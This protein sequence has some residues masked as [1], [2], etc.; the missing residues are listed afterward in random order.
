MSSFDKEGLYFAA[1]GGAEEVGYNMYVYAV[2]GKLIVVDCGY[3]FL[4]DDFPGMEL[5]FAS[6]EA[7]KSEIENIEGLFITHSH[8]D[9]FG[10]VA[11]IWPKLRCPIYATPFAAAHVVSR[12]KD[13]KLEKEPQI[14]IVRNGESVRL[15]NFEVR[16]A[17]LVH[18]TLENS[19]LLIRTRYGNAVHATDWRFDD[20]SCGMLPTDYEVLK[21]FAEEGVEVF[22]CDSTNLLDSEEQPTEMQIRASLMELVPTFQNKLVATCFASNVV[23]LESLI[24]AAHAAGRTPVIAGMSLNQNLNMAKEC[25]YLQNLPPYVNAKDAVDI[26]N[27]KIMYICAGSQGNYRSGL[28]RIVN[29]ENKDMILCPGDAV[30]FSSK[31]IP[32]NEKKIERMQEKLRDQGV[33]VISKEEYLVHCSGHGGKEETRRMYELLKPNV[34]I[35][36]HGERRVIREHSRFAKS[37]GIRHVVMPRNGDVLLLNGD[38]VETVGEVPTDILGVDRNQITSV[39]S[40]LVKNRKRI[41]YNSSVFITAMLKAD[42]QVEDLQISSIDILEETA[43][44]ELS[45]AIKEDMLKSIP[46]EVIK[47]NYRENAVKEYISAKIRKK[48]YNATGIKP[49]VFMH[50]YKEAE[51]AAP[52]E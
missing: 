14:N 17:S 50:F 6:P 11:H 22:A 41:A 37:C 48:I 30:I 15:Q 4:N 20:G 38:S 2:D 34:L 19:A 27:D 18:S 51:P 43:W 47:L 35:A 29:R 44:D 33:Q 21:A 28:T 42:W 39:N 24:L 3:G 49:V 5:G 9:H 8:E 40:Q 36:V 12:L 32:G 26:P 45:A 13:Y 31:I 7:L 25:G 16:F 52:Q 1:L 46:E 23:R 10:A